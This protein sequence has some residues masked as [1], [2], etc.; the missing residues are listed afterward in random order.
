M[1]PAIT[2]HVTRPMPMI[3]CSACNPVIAQYSEK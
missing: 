1:H 3:M 2:I